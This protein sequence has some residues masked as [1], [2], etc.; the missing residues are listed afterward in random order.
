MGDVYYVYEHWRPD[1]DVCFYVGKGKGRRGNVMYR[2]DEQHLR[3][4]KKLASMGMCVE[5]RL[6]ITNLT[7]DEALQHE[8]RRISFWRAF[9]VDLVN[10]TAGGEGG[11]NP[12]EETREKMRSAKVGRKL[13]EDHKEKIATATK[14]ALSCPEIRKRLKEESNRP[15]R[16][17]HAKGLHKFVPRT[18]EHYQKVSA[19]LTGKKLS[20]EHAEK[21]KK[22]SLG[23]KQSPEEIERRRQANTGKKRSDEFRAKMRAMWT[24]ERKAAHAKKMAENKELLEKM[25]VANFGNTHT[26]GKK[27]SEETR[28]KMRKA[29][30]ACQIEKEIL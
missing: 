5:V 6:V 13:S 18:K 20:P 17:K 7:E 4:Q 10:R 14:I 2:R 9:G 11:S 30:A 12:C 22:A 24:P 27:H 19:V 21:T 25:R 8:V 23:R 15:E 29:H 1:L 16:V 28:A 3:I 26:L